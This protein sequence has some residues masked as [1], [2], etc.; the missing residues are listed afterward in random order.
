M[1][2]HY[3]I[4]GSVGSGATS[5]CLE[6]HQTQLHNHCRVCGNLLKNCTIYDCR[7]HTEKLALL[8]VDCTSDD[9]SIHPRYLCNR[10][11]VAAPRQQTS[12]STVIVAFL[13][14]EHRE[15]ECQVHS[16]DQVHTLQNMCRFVT[17]FT[18]CEDQ[19]E[20][21]QQKEEG[22]QPMERKW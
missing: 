10:C 3:T 14:K 22:Q 16:H 18:Y 15:T 6:F 5:T 11:F 20:G 2:Q 12:G 4:M 7:K 9:G 8:G 1:L 13:W 17:I 21:K 19:D